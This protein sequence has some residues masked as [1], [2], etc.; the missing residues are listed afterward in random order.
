MSQENS[1][2]DTEKVPEKED[3]VVTLSTCSNGRSRDSRYVVHCIAVK[4]G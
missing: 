2:Y 1:Y 4:E 3:R